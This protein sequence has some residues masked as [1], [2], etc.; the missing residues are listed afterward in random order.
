MKVERVWAMTERGE[1]GER[2]RDRD[3]GKQRSERKTNRNRVREREPTCLS[4]LWMID[5]LCK[6]SMADKISSPTTEMNPKSIG[7]F[8][9]S[10][11]GPN[12]C[13]TSA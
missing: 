2:Q 10:K 11:L 12:R 8:F 5:L 1:R 9:R 4:H 7:L 13:N 3:Q 6:S